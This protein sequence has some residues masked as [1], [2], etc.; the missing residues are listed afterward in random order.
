M[1][2]QHTQRGRRTLANQLLDT[3]LFSHLSEAQLA[4]LTQDA[5]EFTYPAHVTMLAEGA[6]PELA[7]VILGGA[8]EQRANGQV[9]RTIGHGSVVYLQEAS[10]GSRARCSLVSEVPVRG[11]AVD[12]TTLAAAL[13]S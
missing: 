13:A 3:G 11:V 5:Q 8:A 2:H 9:V 12:P 4:R 10:A 6:T 1:H 7:L